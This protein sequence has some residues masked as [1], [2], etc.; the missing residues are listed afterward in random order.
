R[1]VRPILKQHCWQCHGEERELQGGLDLRLTRSIL[2][3]GDSGSAIATDN[4]SASLL[5]KKI[6]ENEMPPGEKKVPAEQLALIT[7]WIDQG[8]KVD[9]AE[10]E[11][12]A[13]GQVILEQ[14]KRHWAFQ[15]IL[16]HEVPNLQDRSRIRTPIDAFV[17]AKLE[18]RGGTLSDDADKQSQLRRLYLDM[19]GLPPDRESLEAAFTASDE[20]WYAATVDRILASPQYGERWARHWLDVVGYADSNG[21][22]DKD[23]ERKWAWRYRDYVVRSLDA[24]KPW[25][26]MIVE[27][28]AGDELI[29][30]PLNDLTDLDRDRLIATGFLRMVPDGTADSSVD[31][32]AASNDV[33]AETIKVVSSSLL[34]L[35]VGCA[36]CHSHRY[37]PISDGD[38]YAFRAIFEPALSCK[39]WKRPDQR[40][41]SLWSKET[42]ERAKQVDEELKEVTGQRDSELDKMV[43]DTFEHELA[44]LPSEIQ[45]QARKIRQTKAADRTSDDK[46]LLKEYPFLNVD[47]GS[48]Y[49]YLPDRQRAFNQKWDDAIGAVRKK[50]PAEDL[51]QCLMEPKVGSGGLPKTFVFYRGDHQAPRES[52]EPAELSVLRSDSQSLSC[53]AKDGA[54]S[55]RR[56]SYANHLTDGR[57]PLVARVL[58]N[59]FWMHHFGRG[60]V[61]TPTDFGMLGTKPSHPE[62][63]DWLADEFMSS[64]W[65]L[66]HLHRL[67]LSSSVY[68]QSSA[69]RPELEQFDSDNVYLGRMPI[70]RLEA[71]VVR[72]SVLATS[73]RLSNK[74]FGAPAPVAPDEVGQIIV[75]ADTR[76]SAGRPTGKKVNIG[77][78]EFRRS[79]YVQVRRSM[80][81]GVLEPF[82]NPVMVPNCGQRACSTVAP[83]SLLM[84]NSQF[85][86]QQAEAFAEQL[87]RHCP[88]GSSKAMV[89]LAWTTALGRI[90]DQQSLDEA[91]AFL[92]PSPTDGKV[93]DGKVADGTPT[94]GKVNVRL[95]Q[96]CQALLCSNPFLYRE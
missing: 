27:Q 73:G 10:P 76:D 23:I 67:I 34:G 16:R 17:Q 68:R 7:R 13:V 51:V 45:E 36:Q 14:D 44:K 58:V 72:D 69:R 60:L 56:Y 31:V 8:A 78:E 62:L 25:D 79:V 64:G 22:T 48:V 71:E 77:E 12:L 5:Y 53:S 40:L 50:K 47:R 26:E 84:M 59:R 18:S 75:G 81:L 38:Y 96:F 55:R 9:A 91:I 88:D 86:A 33:M 41:V 28:L 66:K 35:T 1:T 42:Q 87:V 83:Q 92:G 65:S 89:E 52:V 3:G 29:D 82:D 57:H 70:L 63:L 95:I 21:Y 15:P 19:L 74:R 37:D 46:A 94:G 30:I 93:A 80:P 39:E 4:H 20:N 24:D 2:K 90:P 54:T 61:A 32:A 6:A 85:A 49:L 43:Q 11:S